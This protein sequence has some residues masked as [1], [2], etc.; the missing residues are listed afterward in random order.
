VSSEAQAD[1]PGV[2]DHHYRIPKVEVNVSLVLE[3]GR[4]LE[5]TAHVAT[6]AVDHVGRQRLIELLSSERAFMPI[7]SP[8]ASLLVHKRR[9]V[10]ATVSDEYDASLDEVETGGAL[11]IP[12]RVELCGVPPE[13]SRVEGRVEVVMPPTRLRLLDFLN[14]IG[15]FLPV[16]TPRGIALVN[17]QHVVSVAQL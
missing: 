4:V 17:R 8:E 15:A 1:V 16:V 3:G 9:I 11:E 5:G 2:R 12:V 10:V 7:T 14:E 6:G 13:L